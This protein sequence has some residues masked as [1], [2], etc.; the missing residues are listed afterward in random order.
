MSGKGKQS[1]AFRHR[2]PKVELKA[3]SKS[4]LK[5]EPQEHPKT[6]QLKPVHQ[7]QVQ[8]NP[9]QASLEA[10]C[11]ASAVS[12]LV[13]QSLEAKGRK[14]KLYH[15]ASTADVAVGTSQSD[16]CELDSGRQHTEVFGRTLARI[17]TALLPFAADPHFSLQTVLC[18]VVL[19]SSVHQKQHRPNL[20]SKRQASSQT[21]A[22]AQ[23]LTVQSQ[24]KLQAKQSRQ[25]CPAGQDSGTQTA[26][27]IESHSASV[28]N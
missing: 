11:L 22:R 1:E 8:E 4:E 23:L 21:K 28:P 20:P 17:C 2:S 10:A 9:A 27:T 7:H 5:V 18:K 26:K 25:K 3:Q 24:A 14:L 15:E 13:S 6:Q 19:Q 12:P 16:N